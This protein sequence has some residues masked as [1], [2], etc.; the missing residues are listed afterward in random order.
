MAF[1]ILPVLLSAVYYTFIASDIYMSESR[2]VIKEPG[3]KRTSSSGIVDLIQASGMGGSQNQA[4][5]VVDY[6]R[7]RNGLADLQR[8]IKVAGRFGEERADFLSRYPRPWQDENFESLYDY[9]GSMVSIKVDPDSNSVVLNVRAF[10]ARDARDVNSQLL[11]LGEQMVNRL[12]ARAQ[13]NAIA[14]AEQRVTDATDRVRNALVGMQQYR[15]ARSVLDPVEQAT[16]VFEVSNALVAQQAALRARLATMR[17]NAPRNPAIPAIEGQIAALDAQ[18]GA[19]NGRAVGTA[20]GLA[21]KLAGYE[22][23]QIEQRFATQALTSASAT[24]EQARIDAQK[25]Q[26]YV[27][28]VVNPNLPDVAVYPKR[29]RGVLVALAIALAFYLIGWMLIVGIL[30]HS[31]DD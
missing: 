25:Q 1:V 22:K 2:F 4:S 19:Q 5:E 23:L 14:E 15:N 18:I 3:A 29:L 30:E 17:E 13:K 10:E 16:G 27:E 9:Y 21:N 31:P 20:D 6:L 26:F 11:V 24:L 12:N 8:Q 7:S 28:R